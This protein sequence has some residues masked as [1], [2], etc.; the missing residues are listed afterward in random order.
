MLRPS[1]TLV[2]PGFYEHGIPDLDLNRLIANNCT[3]V[4]AA[5]TPNV[6]PKVLD[7]LT[8]RHAALKPMITDRFSFKDVIEGF[9]AV[10]ARNESRVKVMIEF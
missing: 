8:N 3:L 10:T 7:L 6:G 5:G 2:I 4:G 9:N 1:G